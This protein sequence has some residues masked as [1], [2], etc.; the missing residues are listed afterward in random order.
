M[1][2]QGEPKGERDRAEGQEV[3]GSW[4][5]QIVG[6]FVGAAVALLLAVGAQQLGWFQGS[7]IRYVLWGGVIGG[8][9][10][11]SDRLEQAGSR[12]TRLDI[13]WLNITV[14]ILGMAIVFGVLFAIALGVSTLIRQLT[15]R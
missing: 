3:A 4:E 2:E 5:R 7:L 1:A 15:G 14:A 11:G 12:L 13:R 6:A 10:G 9:V 8:L